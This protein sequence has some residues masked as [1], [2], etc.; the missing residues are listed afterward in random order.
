M[1]CSRWPARI[2]QGWRCCSR[3]G[4][5]SR[6]RWGF[7]AGLAQLGGWANDDIP[8]R[9]GALHRNESRWSRRL[10]AWSIGRRATSR[11]PRISVG[12]RFPS[13]VS[14]SRYRCRSRSPVSG[15]SGSVSGSVRFGFPVSGIWCPVMRHRLCSHHLPSAVYRLPCHLLYALSAICHLPSA[16]W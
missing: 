12:R 1:A 9:R 11:P 3:L 10:P 6:G 16:R 7:D 14:R 8:N 15:F 5:G 13:P 4:P 2:S